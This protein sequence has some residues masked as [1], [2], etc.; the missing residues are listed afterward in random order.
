MHPTYTRPSPDLSHPTFDLFLD[1]LYMCYLQ[2][3]Q[4]KLQNKVADVGAGGV[5][6]A[7]WCAI[8]LRTA[9]CISA[10]PPLLNCYANTFIC[11]STLVIRALYL[12]FL[13]NPF[14]WLGSPL[15]PLTWIGLEVVKY[16]S[17]R[18]TKM[19][20]HIQRLSG[21]VLSNC[22]SIYTCS[23]SGWECSYTLFTAE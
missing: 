21:K 16:A 13:S 4:A 3:I 1:L 8:P 15:H 19:H 7:I 12:N 18:L 10:A 6:C 20:K 9:Y 5:N 17:Q 11:T 14:C 22:L 2:F 23:L